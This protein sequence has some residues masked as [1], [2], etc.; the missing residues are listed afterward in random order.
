MGLAL[1]A[2]LAHQSPFLGTSSLPAK[3]LLVYQHFSKCTPQAAGPQAPKERGSPT[4]SAVLISPHDVLCSAKSDGRQ[5]LSR[6]NFSIVNSCC[7]MSDIEA[8]LFPFQP[9]SLPPHSLC[10]SFLP[11]RELKLRPYPA[12]SRH[13]PLGPSGPLWAPLFQGPVGLNSSWLMLIATGLG[14]S[15]EES[16][17]ALSP[18][19]LTLKSAS[20]W[21]WGPS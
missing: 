17:A 4:E 8:S 3:S 1:G 11:F 13:A 18:C 19:P 15:R 6:L 14:M 21:T 12:M 2:A 10:P 20:H 9:L 7:S 16:R 5:I